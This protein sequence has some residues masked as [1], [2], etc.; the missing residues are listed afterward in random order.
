[1]VGSNSSWGQAPLMESDVHVSNLKHAPGIP[2]RVTNRRASETLR[3]FGPCGPRDGRHEGLHLDRHGGNL[4]RRQRDRDGPDQGRRGVP[5]QSTS[6]DPGSQRRG[7]GLPEGGRDGGP[8]RR[9][10]L[11]LRQPDP[12]GAARGRHAVAR[13]SQAL[14]EAKTIAPLRAKMPIRTVVEFRG[15]YAADRAA[16][17]PTVRR[18]AGLRFEFEAADYPAAFRTFY[19]MVTIAGGD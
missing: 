11:E 10:A 4:R 9:L 14:R 13:D 6:D 17:I 16:M 5:A 19:A 15:T 7:R 1:M 8:R 18:I 3:G 12:G 2:R